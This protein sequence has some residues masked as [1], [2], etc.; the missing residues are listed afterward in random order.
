LLVVTNTSGDVVDA[1]VDDM[2]D[3]IRRIGSVR[4]VA[5]FID[6]EDSRMRLAV[7]R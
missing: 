4:E 5:H 6:D 1:A 2:E 3:H 7:R